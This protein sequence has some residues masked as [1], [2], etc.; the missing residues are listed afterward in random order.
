MK[1]FRPKTADLNFLIGSGRTS[2]SSN[3]G[4]M[5]CK[6]SFPSGPG[7][8][9]FP[10]LRACSISLKSSEWRV[11]SSRGAK[12][13]EF[14]VSESSRGTPPASESV[15]SATGSLGGSIGYSLATPFD[16]SPD[17]PRVTS[18]RYF[19]SVVFVV[20]SMSRSE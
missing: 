14:V 4:L 15:I 8:L 5:L 7:V 10:F 2:G 19:A 12:R 16:P 17:F 18:L 9:D 11:T 3:L 13:E 6:S 1:R 20:L